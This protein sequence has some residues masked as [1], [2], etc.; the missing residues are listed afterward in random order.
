MA[1]SIRP[2]TS[3]NCPETNGYSTTHTQRARI[4]FRLLICTTSNQET[5][6]IF[7][8]FTCRRHIKENGGWIHIPDSAGTG[9]L[10]AS[11]HRMKIRGDS[12]ISLISA[13]SSD[14]PNLEQRMKAG[15]RIWLWTTRSIN[16]TMSHPPHP[17]C[18]NKSS[19]PA[20]AQPVTS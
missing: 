15:G 8:G 5:A 17:P 7:D 4:E 10:C 16:G 9:S 20:L 18:D 2:V 14:D 6:Q 1:F 13:G 12:C 11:T 3:V 19:P